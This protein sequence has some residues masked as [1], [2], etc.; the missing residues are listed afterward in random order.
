M[1]G[2]WVGVANS[3]CFAVL[4]LFST[5]KSNVCVLLCCFFSLLGKEM[6]VCFAVLF[7]FPTRKRNVLVPSAYS[8]NSTVQ[9]STVQYSTNESQTCHPVWGY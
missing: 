1:L 4:F 9:Y 8:P 5:R 6:Y 7:L 2:G 3:E